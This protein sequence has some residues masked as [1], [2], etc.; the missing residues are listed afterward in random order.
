M[1][2]ARFRHRTLLCSDRSFVPTISRIDA[3]KRKK[4][5]TKRATEKNENRQEDRRS[6]A[7][8]C[9]RT[10]TGRID[11]NRFVR[12]VLQPVYRETRGKS[13]E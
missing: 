2:R 5:R 3:K 8:G 4:K 13:R 10:L 6:W 11:A 9:F 12:Y 1:N 7:I